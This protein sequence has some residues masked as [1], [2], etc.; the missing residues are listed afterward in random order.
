MTLP[1]IVL[2]SASPRRRQL[3]EMI[4]LDILI[5]PADVQEIPLP[6]ERPAAY[7][8]R[9]ARDKARAVPGRLVL[10]ADTIVVIDDSILEKPRD[11]SHA[12]EMLLRLQGRSH[13]VITSIC[14]IADGVEHQATD[15][16]TV[17]FRAADEGW[18]RDYIAT[19]EPL[20]KAGG[21][22]IQGWGAALVERIE[23]DFFGVMGLP[24]RLV[25]QLLAEAGYE[26]RFGGG[27]GEGSMV[28]GE[29]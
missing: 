13:E 11:D 14:L 24:I 1:T 2:A 17:T 25:L 4:G 16:T 26:Y 27:L 23:G 15:R 3:L 7:A 20:D 8:R 5:A 10:G 22:G 19:G 28:K 12:L 18:L 29:R 9:L 21:Y 6:R